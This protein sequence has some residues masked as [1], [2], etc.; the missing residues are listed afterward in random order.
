MSRTVV[1]VDGGDFRINGELTYP[2][3]TWRGRRVEGLLLNS[4]FVQATFND[5]NPET[6]S[7][8]DRPGRPWDPQRNTDEFCA[9]LPQWRNAG[10]VSFTFNLQGG[11]PQGYSRQQPWH[12]SA[13]EPDGSLRDADLQRIGQVLDAAD[14][15]GMAPMLGFFYFGQ[16]HRFDSDDAIRAATD[17]AVEWLLSRGDRHVIVEV[18]NEVDLA[19]Y[20][21]CVI[22]S[23]RCHELIERIQQRSAGKIDNPAGRLLVGTSYSGGKLPEDNIV[24]VNDVVMLHGNGVSEPTRIGEMVDYTRNMPSYR[25]QPIVFNEDDHFDFDQPMNNFVAAVSAGA[26]WG[27]FD[28]R[29]PGEGDEQGYQSVPT[30]WGTN[31][32]RKRGFFRLLREIT[33]N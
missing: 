15:V 14:D 33:G 11:S 13:Y 24:K 25:G 6:R 8:W 1:S 31:S 9:M 29:M 17:N 30:D 10:L 19:R 23:N 4:R 5:R 26:S 2:G 12:N 27:L 21:D 32:E 16:T 3:R 18:G 20:G 7:M 28:W 22:R